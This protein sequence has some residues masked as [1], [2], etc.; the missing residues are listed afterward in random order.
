[1]SEERLTEEEIAAIE[2]WA[3]G[4]AETVSTGVL[5]LLSDLE[6]ASADLAVETATRTRLRTQESRI[7]GLLA[8]AG[9]SVGD[10][11]ASVA[12]LVANRD[13]LRR[14]EADIIEACERVADGGQ[15][16]A[17]IVSAIMRIRGERDMWRTNAEEAR[18]LV[19]RAQQEHDEMRSARDVLLAE[20]DRLRA[21][22]AERDEGDADD[23]AAAREA[24]S[25][26]GSL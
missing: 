9:M 14:R 15:Y 19:M 17:D 20:V 18:G 6:A 23:L 3:C 5:R 12:A 11:V 24:A 7:S 25:F 4:S 2:V 26:G 8:D 13:H 1:M 10:I 21:E 22:S 16:R